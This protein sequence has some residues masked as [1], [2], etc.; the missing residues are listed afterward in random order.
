MYQVEF[1]LFLLGS[2]KSILKIYSLAK[3]FHTQILQTIPGA[4]CY[5]RTA[6]AQRKRTHTQ[7]DNLRIA[8]RNACATAYA[9][10]TNSEVPN[11]TTTPG[12]TAPITGLISKMVQF[13]VVC[14]HL[15][16]VQVLPKLDSVSENST[17]KAPYCL[18]D[19]KISI[20]IH[21]SNPSGFHLYI[22]VLIIISLA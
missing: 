9:S 10:P 21:E 2:W 7:K 1:N 13:H 12:R 22:Q 6:M 8:N 16:R 3:G 19:C 5:D 20:S 14:H 15:P 17:I 18:A 4:R 11:I